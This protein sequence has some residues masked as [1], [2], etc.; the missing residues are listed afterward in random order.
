[1]KRRTFLSTLTA[2]ALVPALK[3]N[4]AHAKPLSRISKQDLY[5]LLQISEV[6]G[7]AISGIVRGRPVQQVAGLRVNPES[8]RDAKRDSPGSPIELTTY[9]PAASLTKP[10]FAWAVLDL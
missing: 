3:P 7:I 10:I 5:E 4:E 2:A 1:M 9:F 6:P 8:P